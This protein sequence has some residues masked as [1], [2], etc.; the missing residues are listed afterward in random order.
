MLCHGEQQ[1]KSTWSNFSHHIDVES[2]I[3]AFDV[4]AYGVTEHNVALRCCNGRD[5]T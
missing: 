3:A 4:V 2:N 1:A 5:V